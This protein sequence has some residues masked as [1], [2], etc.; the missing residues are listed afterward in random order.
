MLT[1]TTDLLRL[2]LIIERITHIDFF[3]LNLTPVEL[4]SANMVD[5]IIKWPPLYHQLTLNS[6][7]HWKIE[8]LIRSYRI[9]VDYYIIR[10]LFPFNELG[11]LR[12]KATLFCL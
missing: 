4:I 3:A 10:K 12:F 7:I 8:V 5:P 6:V 2:Y 9:N 11:I 1:E